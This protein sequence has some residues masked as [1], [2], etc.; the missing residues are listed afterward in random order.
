M[1]Q[2]EIARS[3]QFL[4][5]PQYFQKTYTADMWKPGL[6]WERVKGFSDTDCSENN[7]ASLYWNPSK[8]IGVM[9]RTK[10]LPSSVTLTLSLPER[11]FQMAH[12]HCDGER[13]CQIIAKSIRNCRSYG[14]D[15]FG[16]TDA[17]TNTHKPN[18][19][20]NNYVSLTA[21]GLSKNRMRI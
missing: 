11:I 10:I 18:C 14:L 2:G 16:R 5:F 9:V 4:L 6:V 3:E 12:L 17:H 13:K 1:G 15:K 7:Y 19:Y 8:I 21:S 20:C